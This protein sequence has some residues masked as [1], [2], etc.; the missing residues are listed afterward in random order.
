MSKFKSGMK[1]KWEARPNGYSGSAHTR[2]GVFCHYVDHSDPWTSQRAHIRNV[3]GTDRT[4]YI[5]LDRLEV[6][7]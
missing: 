3:D 7:E 5:D 1:V 6:A 2:T 4:I